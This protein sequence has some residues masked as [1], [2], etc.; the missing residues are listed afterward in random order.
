MFRSVQWQIAI[1]YIILI[2]IVMTGLGIYLSN[3]F[4]QT[5][6]DRLEK[7]MTSEAIAISY[8]LSSQMDY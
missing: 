3:N 7:E 8:T 5:Q 1:P 4:R 2:I 6:I